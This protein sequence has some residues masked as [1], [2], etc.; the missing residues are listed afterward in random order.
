ME[1][2]RVL[3]HCYHRSFVNVA[4][5][6]RSLNF[7]LL[8][9]FFWKGELKLRDRGREKG[10]YYRSKA[11]WRWWFCIGD[12]WELREKKLGEIWWER[13]GV[14]RSGGWIEERE[15]EREEKGDVF[16]ERQCRGERKRGVLVWIPTRGKGRMSE[17]HVVKRGWY[18][19]S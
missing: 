16:S 15:R 7:P 11:R 3:L 12:E 2:L 14:K 18:L 5:N 8:P 17:W 10:D 9:T 19:Q 6:H 13:N 1:E 4:R